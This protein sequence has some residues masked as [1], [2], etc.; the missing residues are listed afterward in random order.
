MAA[1]GPA[2]LPRRTGL[3]PPMHSRL[4]SLWS[5]LLFL[6]ILI[7]FFLIFLSLVSI[8]FF[9]TY[10]EEHFSIFI[11]RLIIIIIPISLHFFPFLV[12]LSFSLFFFRVRLGNGRKGRGKGG[13]SYLA[14]VHS[15]AIFSHFFVLFFSLC[16]FPPFPLSLLFIG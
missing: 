9:V 15:F 10:A 4:C 14:L 13:G 6:S 7:Y 5:R 11:F 12:S 3:A 1:P 8:V 16:F 2:T